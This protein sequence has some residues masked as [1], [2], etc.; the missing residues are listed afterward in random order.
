M[1]HDR[2]DRWVSDSRNEK[3]HSE[4]DGKLAWPFYNRGVDGR[5]WVVRAKL[6]PGIVR[7]DWASLTC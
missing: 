7:F 2:S 4:C 5:V 6:L 1:V 3:P